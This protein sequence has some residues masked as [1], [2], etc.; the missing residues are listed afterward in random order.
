MTDLTKETDRADG[1]F[2]TMYKTLINNVQLST[3][4]L[5]LADSN[6]ILLNRE[7]SVHAFKNVVL[8]DKTKEHPEGDMLVVYSNGGSQKLHMWVILEKIDVSCYPRLLANILSLATIMNQFGVT[9]D[10]KQEH[11]FL[12]G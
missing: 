10:L 11:A 4:P 2:H 1:V 8:L 12:F 3:L 9:L 6:W 5:Q 7:S